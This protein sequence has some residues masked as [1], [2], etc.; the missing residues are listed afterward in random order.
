M[1][2]A[3]SQSLMSG[4]FL[5][6]SSATCFSSSLRHTHA[7]YHQILPIFP[8]PFFPNLPHLTAPRPQS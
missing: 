5:P 1:G 8:P 3:T 7:I 6:P 2:P 4:V